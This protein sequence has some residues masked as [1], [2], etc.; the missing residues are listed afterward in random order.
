MKLLLKYHAW[1]FVIFQIYKR[2]YAFLPPKTEVNSARKLDHFE[3]SRLITSSHFVDIRTFWSEFEAKTLTEWMLSSVESEYYGFLHTRELVLSRVWSHSMLIILK[4]SQK[5][6]FLLHSWDF[7]QS[8]IPCT[9]QSF[10]FYK[11]YKIACTWALW[12]I[13]NMIFFIEQTFPVMG[14]SMIPK[15]WTARIMRDSRHFG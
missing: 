11:N 9:H 3:F 5:E 6:A 1:N 12:C 8:N 7:F 14:I 4:I 2:F 10:G 15:V 13:K